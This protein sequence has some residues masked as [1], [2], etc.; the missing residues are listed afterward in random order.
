MSEL[1]K[2]LFN[3]WVTKP[4]G[5]LVILIITITALTTNGLYTANINDM[6]SGMGTMTEYM[7]MA[8]YATTIGMMV[9]FPLLIQIKGAFTSRNI[10]FVTLGGTLLLSLWCA[11]TTSPQVLIGCNLVMGGFKMFTM[12]E[13]I[14]PIMMMI[15]PDGNRGRFYAVFYPVSIALG[16]LGAYFSAELSYAFGWQYVYYFMMPGLLLSLLLVTVFYHNGRTSPYAP[17][18]SIDWQ[19]FLLL[20]TSLMLLNYVLV[21]AKVE[22]YFSYVHIQ[23]AALGFVITL[24]LFIK[25]QLTSAQPFLNLRILQIRN[26]WASQAMVFLTGLFLA[27][28]SIQSVLTS[29]ILKYS[30]QTNAEL[31]LWMIP[32]VIVGGLLLF[33]WNKYE[34]NHKGIILIGF[35]A[36]VLGYLLLYT[37]VNPGAGMQDFYLAAALR[38]FGM[39]V[40]F[41][42]LGVYN[43]VGL[44]MMDMLSSG[45]VLVVF[46]SFLG[47]A[48]FSALISFGMYQGQ[49]EHLHQLAQHMDV[50]NTAVMA[51]AATSG[52]TLGLYGAAMPQAVLVAAREMLGY[53]VMAGLWIML[54]VWLFRF[55]KMNRRR[56]VN[57]RKKWRSIVGAPAVAG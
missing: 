39:V 57:W 52:G 31:N 17:F 29:G 26:V 24:L 19:S 22:D 30:A 21:F 53:V 28:G 25:R 43:A 7:M 46:R 55:G 6:V 10:L 3:D 9:V 4:L 18:K 32:G 35:G 42:G 23:G 50:T 56:L 2:G 38:G 33:F 40:L 45:A 11:V 48:F 14:V 15:S 20:T 8:N 37:N 13:V 44:Q 47:P 41:A 51:R 54:I 27:A 49:V 36:F 34:H 12:M 5:L 16:Q 1:R